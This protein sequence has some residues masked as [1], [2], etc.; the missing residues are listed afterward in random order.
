MPTGT[1]SN[2]CKYAL[3]TGELDLGSDSIKCL[4]MKTGYVFNKDNVAMFKN[5]RANSASQTI[6]C[7]TSDDSINGSS[8]DF[9]TAGFIPGNLITTDMGIA[10][11]QGPF[12]ILTVTTT[13]IVVDANL[14]N[15]GPTGAKT[16][17]SDDELESG[18]GYTQNTYTLAGVA[19]TED[20]GNDRAELTCNSVVW[21]ATGGSIG[22]T[23]G[24]ILYDDTST[25]NTVLGYID[26]GAEMTAGT[27]A[28]FTIS[29]IKIRLT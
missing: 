20:D 16:V 9:V 13:K 10:D 26:F 27:G 21:T 23:P 24:A 12:N 28:S 14:T 3:M 17:S 8:G 15:E 2:H 1:A 29:N 25:D 11:N 18:N 6:T 7:Q 22:P 4:L 19:V 5:I